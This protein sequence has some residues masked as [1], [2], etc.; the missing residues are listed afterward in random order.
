MA[1]S[2]TLVG[3]VCLLSCKSPDK[4][5]DA[6][7][8]NDNA[9]SGGSKVI[10]VNTFPEVKPTCTVSKETMDSWFVGDSITKGGQVKAANSLN[11]LNSNGDFYKWSW[12]MFLWQTSPEG[13]GVIFNQPPFYDVDSSGN[14]YCAGATSGDIGE[15]TGVKTG[16]VVETE[17]DVHREAC[18]VGLWDEVV[19]ETNSD[20]RVVIIV[21]CCEWGDRC[22]VIFEDDDVV[23]TEE[24]ELLS[25]EHVTLE[26]EAFVGLVDAAACEE[27][28]VNVGAHV[29]SEEAPSV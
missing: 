14:V 29:R 24:L 9:A 10:L 27:V 6:G 4:T 18:S 1:F 19:V 13:S 17:A 16:G 28:V 25:H 15:A 3:S 7:K 20:G 2:A 11:A 12:Q 21:G 23:A 22:W 26:D 5:T 8:T